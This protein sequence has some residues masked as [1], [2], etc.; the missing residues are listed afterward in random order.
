MQFGP[1]SA[2][3]ELSARSRSS[4]SRRIPSSSEVSENPDVKN[5]IEPTWFA[6]QSF[7]IRGAIWRGTAL[8]A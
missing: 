3:S 6:T 8:T 4:F 2:I 5:P 1:T 7:K